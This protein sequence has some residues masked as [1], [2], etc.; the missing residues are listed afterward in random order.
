M[1]AR[2]LPDAVD[3]PFVRPLA[4]APALRVAYVHAGLDALLAEPDVLAVLGFGSGAPTA[5]S[6]PRYLRVALEPLQTPAPFEVWRTSGPVVSGSAGRV[7]YAHGERL[8]FGAI[9]IDETRIDAT[10]IDSLGIDEAGAD[11]IASAGTAIAAA[12]AAGYIELGAFLA[13]SG[14]PHVLRF[15][16]YLAAITEGIDDAERYR[17]FCIGRARGLPWRSH[18]PAATAI[19]IPAPA[20][21]DGGKLQ[22]YFLAATSP[23]TPIENPRQLSAYRYPRQ[24]GPQPPTFARAMLAPKDA[25]SHGAPLLI[26]GTASVRGHASVHVDDVSGQLDETLVN[27]RAVLDAARELQPTLPSALGAHSVLKAY[28]RDRSDTAMIETALRTG[29]PVDTALLLLHA[30]ICRA[31]LLI[32]IDGFHGV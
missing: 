1:S 19:G 20:S 30:D 8:L 31:E 7:R 18:Y 5:H 12:A 17:Q 10:G 26:S 11:S 3:R 29:L 25:S 21:T 23:G 2:H 16:N 13:N 28:L 22:I 32:E 4:D 27:L 24:Y 9:E 6:D 14:F 15:W